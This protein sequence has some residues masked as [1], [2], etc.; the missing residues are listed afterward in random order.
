M[1]SITNLTYSLGQRTL[2]QDANLHIGKNDRIALVGDNGAGKSTLFHLIT[3]K[4]TPEKGTIRTHKGYTIGHL[5]QDL[6]GY[7][8]DNTIRQVAIEGHEILHDLQKKIDQ[9]SQKIETHYEPALIEK[10][11]ATQERFEQLGGYKIA[12]SV[13]KILAGLGFSQKDLDTPFRSFS[14]GWRMRALLAKLLL[15][16]P[17]LLLLDEPTNHLDIETI[18]WLEGYLQSYPKEFILISHDRDLLDA[19]TNKTIEVKDGQLKSYSGNYT[20]YEKEKEKNLA[21]EAHT[22]ENQQ[23]TIKRTQGFIDR[24]RAKASK[25]A[26]VQ[27]RIK[28]LKRMHPSTPPSTSK[29]RIHFQFDTPQRGGKVTLSLHEVAKAYNENLIFKNTSAAVN[30]GDKI[31]FISANG[32]GKS[33]LLRMIAGTESP[34][35]GSIKLGHQVEKG[36][37]A[38]HQLEILKPNNTILEELR[39][40]APDEGESTLRKILGN[41]LFPKDDVHKKIAILS[42][43]EK[44]RVALAKILLLKANFLLLDAPTGVGA[45]RLWACHSLWHIST[46]RNSRERLLGG[47][48]RSTKS[49]CLL[50]ESGGGRERLR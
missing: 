15:Q 34:D 3:K 33:T 21:I 5:H 18:K 23:K 8:S 29:S 48:A 19:V 27:S 24:F 50:A 41:F 1:L 25:A 9:L 31:G 39:T 13:E 49:Y 12:G 47:G 44:A 4:H 30:R 43:G 14:G 10:L 28:A 22:Y 26:Q 38:Q 20:F 6:M 11:I 42:G 2:Y 32:K 36:Y 7:T 45:L 17:D 40:S 16:A 46:L 35:E 37:Y